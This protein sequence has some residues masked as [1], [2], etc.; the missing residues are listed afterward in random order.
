VRDLGDTYIQILIW[1]IADQTGKGKGMG[2]RRERG[3]ERGGERGG[4]RGEGEQKKKIGKGGKKA[5]IAPSTRVN[6]SSTD[7][8]EE[9]STD[10]YLFPTGGISLSRR[11]MWVIFRS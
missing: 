4:W 8:S 9:L 2:K 11:S 7:F 3:R 1:E 10:W 6:R 5:Y